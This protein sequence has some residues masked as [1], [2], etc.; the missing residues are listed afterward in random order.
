MKACKEIPLEKIFKSLSDP[1]RMSVVR[2]LLLSKE[3][4]TCGSFEYCV[5]KATFSHHVKILLEAHIICER[6][7]GTRKYL[8]LNPQIKKLYPGLIKTIKDS[9]N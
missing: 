9:Q 3:E 6:V 4:M 2:Q 1:I 5:N 8:K 7:E